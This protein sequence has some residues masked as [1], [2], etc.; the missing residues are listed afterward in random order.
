MIY[1]PVHKT[2]PDLWP[3]G[4]TKGVQDVLNFVEISGAWEMIGEAALLIFLIVMFV[5]Y[6]LNVCFVLY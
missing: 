6:A 3:S 2:L 4:V 1:Y 5:M